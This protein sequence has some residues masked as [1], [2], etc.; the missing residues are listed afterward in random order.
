MTVRNFYLDGSIDGK[1]TPIKG[2]PRAKDGG[3]HLEVKQRSNGEITTPV[4][5]NGWVLENGKLRL[6]VTIT[7]ID[8]DSG[9]ETS[10]S[11]IHK[12]VR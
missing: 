3:F 5:I 9:E 4:T 10:T 11:M 12:T 7:T 6:L 2:G 8:S 1:I